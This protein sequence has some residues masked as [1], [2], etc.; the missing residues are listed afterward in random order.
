MGW[1][2]MRPYLMPVVYITHKC[3]LNCKY[4]YVKKN[5]RTMS[6]EIAKKTVDFLGSLDYKRRVISLFGG[7]PLVEWKLVKKIVGYVEKSGNFSDVFLCTNGTLLYREKIKYFVKHKMTPQISIDGIAVAHDINR[8]DKMDRGSF[9]CLDKNLRLLG[10]E[11]I[12]KLKNLHLR[13]TISPQSIPYLFETMQY[14]LSINLIKAQINMLPE[15]HAKYKELDFRELN[16]QFIKIA[17][18]SKHIKSKG[19]NLNLHYNEC[20]VQGSSF[21][22]MKKLNWKPFCHLADQMLSV[23]IEGNV[24][25]CYIAAGIKEDKRNDLKLGTINEKINYPSK[26]IDLDYSKALNPYLSCLAWNYEQRGRLLRPVNIYREM[27]N[28]WIKAF[29]EYMN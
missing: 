22:S 17:K 23:D 18:F 1:K 13:L 19:E 29:R 21:E 5:N 12:N 15:V 24:Y 26:L 9:Y 10:T 11:Y 6:W 2:I 27:Y 20:I 3:N 16:N 4:C 8:R 14:I 7:E 25:P 28:A